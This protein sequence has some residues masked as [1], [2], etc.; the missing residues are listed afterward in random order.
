MAG[1]TARSKVEKFRRD[2]VT[3][4]RDAGRAYATAADSMR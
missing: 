1:K 3:L 2:F 4:A